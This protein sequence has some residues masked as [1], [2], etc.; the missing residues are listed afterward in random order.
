MGGCRWHLLLKASLSPLGHVGGNIRC[1]GHVAPTWPHFHRLGPARLGSA[2]L[3]PAWRGPGMARLGSA[4]LGPAGLGSAWLGLARPGSARPGPEASP[5]IGKIFPP[6]TWSPR[7]GG[8]RKFPAGSTPSVPSLLVICLQA[9]RPCSP[10]PPGHPKPCGFHV[11]GNI[12]C[13]GHVAPTWPHFHRLGLAR[14]GSARLGPDWRG[15]GMAR[16]GSALL[17]QA[18]LGS[19][20]LG[21]AR[22]GSA[23]PG[24]QASPKIGEIFPPPR[25]PTSAN[26]IQPYIYIYIYIYNMYIWQM[27]FFI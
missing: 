21:S 12:Q 2:R 25:G 3:G 10:P 16:L 27:A 4:L 26:E 23:R 5:E 13:W 15:P 18:R 9:A 19:S 24:P 11:G 17:G 14:L 6:A 20:W 8:S 1:W 7:G 22:P